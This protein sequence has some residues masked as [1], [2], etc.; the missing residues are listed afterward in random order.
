MRL[1]LQLGPWVLDL[2]A[3]RAEDN[4]PD[5]EQDT[6]SLDGGST[7]AYPIG[8]TPQPPTQFEGNPDRYGVDWE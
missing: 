6:C 1:L 2:S 3:G 4:T 8:F 5:P 7:V